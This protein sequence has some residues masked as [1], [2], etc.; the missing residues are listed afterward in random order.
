MNDELPIV[1]SGG[2]KNAEIA[3]ARRGAVKSRRVTMIRAV[4][5]TNIFISALL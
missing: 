3:A 1:L 2:R 5:D 4:L